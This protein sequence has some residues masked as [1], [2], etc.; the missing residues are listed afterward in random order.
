MGQSNNILMWLKNHVLTLT[1]VKIFKGLFNAFCFY[2]FLLLPFRNLNNTWICK[3]WNLARALDTHITDQL[4]YI[5]RL[6]ESGPKVGGFGKEPN[7]SHQ[8]FNN[9]KQSN[10]FWADVRLNLQSFYML[11]SFYFVNTWKFLLYEYSL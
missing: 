3:P 8:C 6:R 10:F 11:I 2:H 9:N 4:S 1:Q 5:I 7:L